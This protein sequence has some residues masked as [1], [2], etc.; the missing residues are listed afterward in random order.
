MQF[1]R[2]IQTSRSIKFLSTDEDLEVLSRGKRNPMTNDANARSA[3][4]LL[5]N[6]YESMKAQALAL[7]YVLAERDPEEYASLLAAAEKAAI[8]VIQPIIDTD[9]KRG[10][11]YAALDDPN[12]DWSAALFSMLNQEPSELGGSPN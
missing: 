11:F 1:R 8:A 6:R 9:A 3:L 4:R 2:S 12:A 10:Q 5:M 7:A